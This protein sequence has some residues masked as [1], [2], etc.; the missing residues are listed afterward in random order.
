MKKIVFLDID[1]TLY[2]HQVGI[3]Q[4]A[5]D[6][7]HLAQEQGH[8]ICICTGR[9]KPDVDETIT[10][11]GFDGYITSCGAHVE[12]EEQVLFHHPWRED[13]ISYFIDVLQRHNIGYNLEGSHTSYL[14]EQAMGL[15]ESLFMH[16]QQMNSELARQYM[17]SI[18]LCPIAQLDEIGKQQIMKISVFAETEAQFDFLTQ[19]IPDEMYFMVHAFGNS[20]LLNGEIAYR[21][22]DKATGI[23]H[24]LQHF[25][26][27]L[28]QSIAIGD[29]INDLAMIQHCA[30]GI[31]MEN[32]SDALKKH[33]DE[34]C[35]S[36]VNDGIYHAF[37]KH[38]LL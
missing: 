17:A 7:I 37:K 36:V 14:D 13:T 9:P 26:I 16:E 4:S 20:G 31:G 28:S 18:R 30:I 21:G 33:C 24:V 3:P 6:A 10:S 38:G 12:V 19:N 5:I 27:P 8:I 23:D 15:F 35:P 22:I 25:K 2:D 1:G 32:G 11:I 34:I 29:S